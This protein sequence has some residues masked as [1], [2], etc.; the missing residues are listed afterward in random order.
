MS[1]DWNELTEG[2]NKMYDTSF[3]SDVEMFTILLKDLS[4]KKIANILGVST[5]YNRLDFLGIERSHKSSG[6]NNINGD[7]EATF[8]AITEECMTKMTI[9][10]IVKE[11]E[12]TSQY[13]Y[14]LT[15]KH[16]RSYKMYRIRRKK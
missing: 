10:E 1:I 11:A 3:E 6:M 4:P 2:Y 9:K 14:S 5:I 16:N 12:A 8:L 13:C 15:R 7:K